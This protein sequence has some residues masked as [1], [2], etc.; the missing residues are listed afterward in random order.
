[1]GKNMFLL[2]LCAKK[3]VYQCITTY[4]MGVNEKKNGCIWNFSIPH[5]K[6]TQSVVQDPLELGQRQTPKLFA[7]E[8]EIVIAWKV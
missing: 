6:K 5:G 7:D 4:N 1:M 8:T 3:I 2:H